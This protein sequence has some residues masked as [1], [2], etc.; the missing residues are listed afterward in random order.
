MHKVQIETASVQGKEIP[1]LVVRESRLKMF[2]LLLGGLAFVALALF[3]LLQELGGGTPESDPQSRV[4]TIAVGVMV[5]LFGLVGSVVALMRM[6]SSKGVL[7]LTPLGVEFP[8]LASRDLFSGMQ[9]SRS[10]SGRHQA[11]T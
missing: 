9:F 2:L 5:V 7:V 3:M 10:G 11:V 1:A 4:M 6:F 8:Y